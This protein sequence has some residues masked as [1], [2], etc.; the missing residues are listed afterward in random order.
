MNRYGLCDLRA[1][2]I[3]EDDPE[4]DFGVGSGRWCFGIHPLL[5][6]DAAAT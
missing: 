6:G 2:V 1:L 5:Q 4:R 3:H